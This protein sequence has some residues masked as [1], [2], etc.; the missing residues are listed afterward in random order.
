MEALA[1][2]IQEFDMLGVHVKI[3]KSGVARIRG[4]NEETTNKV[5]DYLRLEA[6]IAPK[7][8]VF[9]DLVVPLKTDSN[10]N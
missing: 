1:I 6:F 4:S 8:T 7:A 2:V 9:A 10:N 3:Y 5:N